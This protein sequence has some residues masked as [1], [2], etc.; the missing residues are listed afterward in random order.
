MQTVR[1]GAV[2]AV[3]EYMACF[4][5]DNSLCKHLKV[6]WLHITTTLITMLAIQ[7]LFPQ[8]NITGSCRTGL[9]QCL[10]LGLYLVQDYCIVRG[11]PCI[12]LNE[13]RRP[14]NEAR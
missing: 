3:G 4:S 5:T 9:W 7:L 1:P 8:I 13:Q 6:N 14:G 11:L 10:C 2:C 12:I